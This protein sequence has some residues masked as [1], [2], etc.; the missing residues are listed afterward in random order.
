VHIDHFRGCDCRQISL[1]RRGFLTG[2]TAV[3]VAAMLPATAKT[4]GAPNLIDTHCHFF[5]PEYERLWQ[6]WDTQRKIPHFP[7]QAAWSRAKTIG[8]G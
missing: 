7:S 4:Q 3:G 2:A 8:Y 1:S 6:D 5:P